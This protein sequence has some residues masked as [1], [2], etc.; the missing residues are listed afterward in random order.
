VVGRDLAFEEAAHL[1]AEEVV[2]GGE[3]GALKHVRVFD[4]T[5]VSWYSV[6]DDAA[7]G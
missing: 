2:F 3:E 1:L 5:L 4:L 7:G 6:S